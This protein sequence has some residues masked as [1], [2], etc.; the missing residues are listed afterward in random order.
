MGVA[1]AAR[2]AGTR[3][4]KVGAGTQIPTQPGTLKFYIILYFHSAYSHWPRAKTPALTSVP[5]HACTEPIRARI[6]IIW[7]RIVSI[8][9]IN[10]LH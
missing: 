2:A 9:M 7:F 6:T 10:R 3:A 4:G 1:R 8:I 5:V